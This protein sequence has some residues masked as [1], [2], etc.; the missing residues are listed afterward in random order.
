LRSATNHRTPHSD[1]NDAAQ[2]M[3]LSTTARI[4]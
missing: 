1:E 2:Y 4:R 3:V